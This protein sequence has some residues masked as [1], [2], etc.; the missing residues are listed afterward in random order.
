MFT[1]RLDLLVGLAAPRGVLHMSVRPLRKN[2]EQPPAL[3]KMTP[4]LLPR[5]SCPAWSPCHALMLPNVW[6]QLAQGHEAGWPCPCRGPPVITHP[7]PEGRFE[8]EKWWVE[9]IKLLEA[10][11]SSEPPWQ[12]THAACPGEAGMHHRW[13]CN[14]RGMPCL[15]SHLWGIPNLWVSQGR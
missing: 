14:C 15:T 4:S 2:Q 8:W 10:E 6:G 1:P 9:G 11:Q 3:R 12:E 7:L 13:R 5:M